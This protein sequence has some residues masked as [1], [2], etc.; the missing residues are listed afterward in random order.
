MTAFRKA[1]VVNQLKTTAQKS[2]TKLKNLI[3]EDP[4]KLVFAAVS[5]LFDPKTLSNKILSADSVMVELKK[6]SYA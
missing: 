2:L 3:A 1:E 4:S 6:S 5:K